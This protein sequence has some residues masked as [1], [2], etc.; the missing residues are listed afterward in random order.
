MS[1]L[2]K[3]HEEL[4]PMGTQVSSKGRWRHCSPAGPEWIIGSRGAIVTGGP[5]QAFVDLVAGLGALTL[6][7]RQMD[8]TPK[9][10]PLPHPNELALAEF[11]QGWIPWAHRMRFLKNGGDATQAA[12]RIARVYTGRDKIVDFGNYHG[13]SDPFITTDHEGVP[14]CIRDLTLRP[15]KDDAGLAMVDET[16]AAVILEMLPI[17]PLPDGFLLKLR[18]RCK[19]VGAVLI[20]DDVIS[21]FRAH[22]QGAAGVTGIIPDLTCAG[23]AMANGWPI[24]VVYGN[25]DIMSC[26]S[27]THLSATHWA[28]PAAMLAAINTLETMCSEHFWGKQAAWSFGGQPNNGHWGVTKLSP[29]D[30]TFVQRELQKR[31]IISNLSQFYYLDLEEHRAAIDSAFADSFKA[32]EEAKATGE[33]LKLDCDINQTVFT[34]N[35]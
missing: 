3:R 25:A 27:R 10:Y 9:C 18:Q 31:G 19:K 22:S 7:H 29:E 24:S 16:V 12:I 2:V 28:D 32:L 21:G 17:T 33:P 34:R 11:I 6:G 26:W 20:S 30:G 14:Q 23:K 1:I 4:I 5:G 13:C 8:E 15:T 35:A